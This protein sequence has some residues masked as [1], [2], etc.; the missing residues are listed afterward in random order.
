MREDDTES[1][2]YAARLLSSSCCQPYA[3][4]G[5]DRPARPA[6]AV[7]RRGWFSWTLEMAHSLISTKLL[8]IISNRRAGNR[9]RLGKPPFSDFQGHFQEMGAD[10]MVENDDRLVGVLS[11]AQMRPAVVSHPVEPALPPCITPP[12]GPSRTVSRGWGQCRRSE[13][14]P[15]EPAHSMCS[16]CLGR[17]ALA[18][19]S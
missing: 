15:F 9:K 2:A 17:S 7:P 13:D 1:A 8:K 16:E 5:L 11:Q 4:Y 18:Y 14:V 19:P 10:P 3:P 6:Q 12:H